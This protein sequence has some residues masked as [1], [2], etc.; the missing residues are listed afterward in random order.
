MASSLD[1]MA[2]LRDMSSAAWFPRAAEL[3]GL[4]TPAVDGDS[5]AIL[6][7]LAFSYPSG[8]NENPERRQS[9]VRT[10]SEKTRCVSWRS[11]QVQAAV[12]QRLALRHQTG[13]MSN[14][15]EPGTLEVD[16]LVCMR[17]A[18]RQDLET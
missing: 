6:T 15:G 2:K 12:P 16:V 17:T 9:H 11:E 5:D 14:A 7:S 1:V 10:A 8:F 18:Q 3:G 4:I 13:P